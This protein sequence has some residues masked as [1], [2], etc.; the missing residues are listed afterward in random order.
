MATNVTWLDTRDGVST[1]IAEEDGKDVVHNQQSALFNQRVLD[2][3]QRA[4]S[5][6]GRVLSGVGPRSKRGYLVGNIPHLLYWKWENFWHTHLRDIMPWK[7]YL[8][9]KL[10]SREY[11]GLK[12][13]EDKKIF[14]P[15]LYRSRARD[16][17]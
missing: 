7:V 6:Q 8:I 17:F 2:D 11:S 13:S 4:R 16:A 3:N 5:L 12:T 1:Y 9:N 14:I 15:E 10:N